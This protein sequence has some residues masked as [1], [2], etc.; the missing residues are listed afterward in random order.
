MESH[1]KC[2]LKKHHSEESSSKMPEGVDMEISCHPLT[3]KHV[4][5]LVIAMER[6]KGSKLESALSSEF[7]DE[8][9]LNVMLDSIVEEEIVIELTSEPPTQSDYSKTLEFD[10][11]LT[12]G[13]QKEWVQMQNSMELLGVMLQGGSNH[14]AVQ[15]RMATY[16]H[17]P[18]DTNAQPVALGIKNSSFF[19]SCSEEGG[20]PTL[21]LETV[22]NKDDLKKISK[23]SD[24]VRFLFYRHDQ[25]LDISTFRSVRFPTWFISTAKTNNQPVDMCEQ[26]ANRN[27]TFTVQ[28]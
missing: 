18:T 15:I 16:R 14:H 23:D 20:K 24:M 7:D 2:S 8:N 13:Q 5:N 3:M 19:L 10:C 22:A 1:S 25:G 4:V 9:F 11:S 28:S 6:F 12:D 27:I 17:L 21:H 26:T